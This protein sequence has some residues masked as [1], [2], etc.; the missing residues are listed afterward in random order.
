MVAKRNILGVEAVGVTHRGKRTNSLVFSDLFEGLHASPESF[1]DFKHGKIPIWAANRPDL[2]SEVFYD[3]Y[4]QF[5][6][7]QVA[8]SVEDPFEGFQSG[9][10]ILIP[11]L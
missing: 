8:N 1:F 11:K 3:T 10:K 4:D 9:D 5:W 6:I 7:L 2:I